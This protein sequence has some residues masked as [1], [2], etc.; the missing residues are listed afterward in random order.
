[1]LFIDG[2][3]DHKR[4]GDR[5]VRVDSVRGEQGGQSGDLDTGTGEPDDD[6]DLPA[7]LLADLPDGALPVPS[8]F[9]LALFGLG[10]R[11]FLAWGGHG[12]PFL[13]WATSSRPSASKTFC[14]FSGIVP[15]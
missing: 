8:R 4:A 13:S 2:N 15:L 10:G 1:M 6:N 5:L 3:R 11:P 9:D 12:W 7:P 14:Q